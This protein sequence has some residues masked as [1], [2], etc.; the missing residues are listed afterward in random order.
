MYDG[1]THL[2]LQEENVVNVKV[3]SRSTI[4]FQTLLRRGVK[5]Y[6]FASVTVQNGLHEQE[7]M[8]YAMYK[9]HTPKDTS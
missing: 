6:C 9:D 5:H 7:S 3:P 8:Y 2:P 4:S 1:V